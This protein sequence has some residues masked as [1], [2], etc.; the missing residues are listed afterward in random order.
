MK[1]KWRKQINT[2]N[3]RKKNI[4]YNNGKPRKRRI[5]ATIITT[6]LLR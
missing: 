3:E 5:N 1:K 6:S 2:I 4:P